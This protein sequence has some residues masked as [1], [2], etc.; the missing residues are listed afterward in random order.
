MGL[1][2]G[3][4]V[5]VTGFQ[6]VDDAGNITAEQ[7]DK[8]E[9]SLPKFPEIKAQSK[10]G[11]Q[12][13]HM[14]KLVRDE[15]HELG[16]T[17]DQIDSQG[18]RITTTFTPKAM[19]AAKAGVLEQRPEGFK[20]KELHIG[21]ASVEPGTGALR[22]FYGGQ[23]FLDSQI[24]WAATGGMVGVTLML[25]VFAG[26]LYALCTSIGESLLQPVNLVQLEEE[27]GP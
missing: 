17:D 27:V 16:Y 11:E 5:I 26:P 23:D 24:N 19:D 10:Y 13:G 20:D 1:L 21:V 22:G 3:R 6:G 8:A 4:V 7:A 12:R 15:L 25:T 9:R 14:L 18:Y 2:D